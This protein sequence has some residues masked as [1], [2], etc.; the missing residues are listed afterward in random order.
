MATDALRFDSNSLYILLSDLGDDY[1]FHWGLYLAKS[2]ESG[3]ISHLTNPENTTTWTYEAKSSANA[4]SSGSLII[5][6]KVA[7][8]EP[9]LV[10]TLCN[11]LAKI[12][13]GYSAHF[14]EDI[15]CR[16]WVKEALFALDEDGYIKLVKSVDDI[17]MEA[18]TAAMVNKYRKQRSVIK[19]V[20][21]L[22]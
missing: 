3:I 14:R 17:E 13:I 10:D 12:P 22:G 16:V 15:T 21:S 2:P 6:V 7:T 20:G 1:R 19:S 9:E 8:I 4:S 18:K 5:A 11:R